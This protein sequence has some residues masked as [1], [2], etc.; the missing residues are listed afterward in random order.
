MILSL[1]ASD[2]SSGLALCHY[3]LPAELKSSRS[4]FSKNQKRRFKKKQKEQLGGGL[5]DI[6]AAITA[7]D[8]DEDDDGRA[9][10]TGQGV[11]DESVHLKVKPKPGRIGEGKGV[12]LKQNQRRRALYVI[13]HC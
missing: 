11:V 8:G 10:Q 1:I 4:S 6:Q 12:P 5:G 13:R 3:F 7:L 2:G 9:E